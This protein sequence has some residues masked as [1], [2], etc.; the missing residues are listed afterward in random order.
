MSALKRGGGTNEISRY[1]AITLLLAVS[2]TLLALLTFTLF[3][4]ADV[5]A[6]TCTPVPA[7]LVSWWPLDEDVR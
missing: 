2:P 1:L 7:G 5:Q 6:Q 3:G 4:T